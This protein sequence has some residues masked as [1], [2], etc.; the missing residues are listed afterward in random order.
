MFKS[1]INYPAVLIPRDRFPPQMYSLKNKENKLIIVY[2]ED[3]KTSASYATVL[4]E[5]GFDNIYM[6][7]GGIEEFYQ[8][9]PDYCLGSNLP[10]LK[11]E[12]GK[13]FITQIS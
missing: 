2:H 11:S 3:D 8:K 12:M 9:K 6:L 5:K 7:T 1:A 13:K 10:P 4:Y